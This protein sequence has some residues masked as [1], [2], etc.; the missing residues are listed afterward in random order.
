MGDAMPTGTSRRTWSSSAAA[1]ARSV[2][3]LVARTRGLDVLVVEK[4]ALIGGSTAMS[5]GG[6]W[7]PNN[8][9]CAPRARTDSEQAALA[10]FDAVVGDVGP[11]SSP[12]RR[13]RLR[14]AGPA[15]GRRSSRTTASR[16]ATPTG[17]PT[18]TPTLRVGVLAAARSR[19]TR[20]TPNGSVRMRAKLRP[21]MS[22][23]L[24][25][26]GFG[27]EL[28]KMSYYNRSVGRLVLAARV[29]LRTQFAKLRGE[30]MVG[31]GGAL[32]GR[33]LHSA[34]DARRAGLDRGP[35][36]GAR[37]RGR[38]RRRRGGR[39]RRE[40]ACASGPATACCS[41]PAAS[42][43][44]TRCASE[45]GGKHARS[46]AWSI[47]NPGDTGEVLQMAMALGAETS[48]LDEAF[49]LPN[50][51]LP[52]GTL[53][54]YPSRQTSAFN[55]ARWRPGS[56]MV[57]ELGSALRER[58]DVVHGARADHVR[59]RRRALVADLRRRVPEALPL[60]RAPR[61]AARAVDQRRLRHA[62]RHRSTSSQRRCDVDA[63]GL[64][65]TVERF[66][67]FARRGVDDDFHR[68]E[69]EY[70]RFMGDPRHKPNNCLAP[71]GRGP[72]YAVAVYPC[73]V[74]T[75][76][77]LV[78]DG[79]ARVLAAESQHADPGSVRD[80]QHH[81]ERDG[82]A[83]PR[84]GRQHRP[85]LHVRLRRDERHRRPRSG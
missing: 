73:D 14:R 64:A 24:G 16:S 6:V 39:A 29:W 28:T 22:T 2:A 68:G 57:D 13:E 35:A 66:N 49:W 17:T 43:A 15:D 56:I 23:G 59:P 83:L 63:A 69:S 78:T 8:P 7:I 50:H 47:S 51:C 32:V 21:G 1:A 71:I 82:S 48:L 38:A 67:G 79:H 42:R 60:R 55:R 52:D 27:T 31:N 76:G 10:H 61:P 44:T 65:A 30:A 36:P 62:C 25:L 40:A 26:I 80:R 33:L 77:G 81:R 4:D 84:R 34:V 53:P 85:H 75:C 9:S 18:T 19:R 74:G 54:R 11:A 20:S 72:F 58:V 5:G 12:E 45:Y 46:A 70:D 41:R 37:G 3:A